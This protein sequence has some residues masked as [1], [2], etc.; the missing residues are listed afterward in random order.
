MFPFEDGYGVHNGCRK[1]IEFE[2]DGLEESNFEVNKIKN[3]IV[4]SRSVFQLYL[5]ENLNHFPLF[6][7]ELK[8]TI[9]KI[10]NPTIYNV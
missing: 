7:T 10:F 8:P 4:A 3:S 2:K 1:T 6:W 9:L 5:T